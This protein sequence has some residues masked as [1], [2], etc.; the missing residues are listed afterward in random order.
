M[1]R[2]PLRNILFLLGAIPEPSNGIHDPIVQ[3]NG[4]WIDRSV[5]NVDAE[6]LNGNFLHKFVYEYK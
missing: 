3:G 5:G 1:K 2:E 6:A 4:R